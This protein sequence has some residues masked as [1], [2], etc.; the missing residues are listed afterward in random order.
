MIARLRAFLTGSLRHKLLALALAPVL[1]FMPALLWLAAD[2]MH[3]FSRDLL[4]RRVNTDLQVAHDAF[5]R[6]R[7]D[8]LLLL[9]SLA[10]SHGFR[11]ALQQ[12]DAAALRNQLQLLRSTAGFDFLTLTDPRGMPRF[13]AAGIDAGPMKSSALQARAALTGVGQ[14]GVELFQAGELRALDAA[15]AERAAVKV[16]SRGRTPTP[17]E[18]RGLVLRVIEPVD[19]AQGSVSGLLDGGVLLNRNF[20]FVDD[21]RDLVYGPG[22]VPR[23]GWGA[24]S[25]FLGDRRI[26]TN[27]PQQGQR[28]ARAL[29]TAAPAEAAAR[30]LDEG[31]PWS[32]SSRVAGQWYVSAYRPILGVGGRPV[33]MLGTDYLASPFRHAWQRALG[34]LLAL[35]AAAM[36]VASGLAVWGARSLFRPLEAMTAVARAEQAGEARRIGP[37]G[38]QDEIA[39]LARQFDRMLDLLEQRSAEVRRASEE[40]ELKVAVRTAELTEKNERLQQLITLLRQTQQRLVHAEKLAALGELT[41]GL[42]HEVNNPTA[43]ILGNMEVMIAELGPQLDPVRTEVDLI[44]EQVQRIRAMVERL[45]QYSRGSGYPT[46]REEIDVSGVVADTLLLVRH[47][48]DS[49][50]VRVDCSF[51]ATVPVRINRQELQ[52]VLVNLMLNAL[53]AVPRAGHVEIVTRDWGT[54][55]AVICVKDYGVGIRREALGHIFDP[56]YT[57]DAEHGTGLGLSVS[58][59]LIRRYGGQIVVDSEENRWTCFD[60]F[61]RRVPVPEE[62]QFDC[63]RQYGDAG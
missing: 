40:L 22:S 43:V 5:E 13:Q 20:G 34:A 53:H 15:L 51:N 27:L 23:D 7:R 50:A 21:I 38:S 6:I 12:S 8:H 56:F 19:D 57:T 44:L 54:I 33:G 28:A 2:W 36:A 25:V 52:Q 17:G 37:V 29:G 45:L 39:E 35:M 60:V 61:L 62:A 16:A 18:E 59:G 55:G 63:D 11:M 48:I 41:A 46:A 14:T 3:D 4:A 10:E 1:L 32:G 9:H 47:E 30:V 26:S 58:Y 24:V 49:K 42:A 31:R